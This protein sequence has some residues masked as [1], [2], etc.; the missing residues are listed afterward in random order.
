MKIL[1]VSIPEDIDKYFFNRKKD[2]AMINTQ[3]S[4]IKLD[5]PPLLLITGSKG[6]GKTFLIKKIF[7]DLSEDI[8]TAYVDLSR[9][10]TSLKGKVTEEE[11]C[12]AIDS[13]KKGGIN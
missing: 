9:F 1:P 13:R 4:T 12:M 8:L 2:I 11:V 3:L 6:I 5:I 10:Q 7:K